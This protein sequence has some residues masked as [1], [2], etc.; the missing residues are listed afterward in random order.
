LSD[1]EFLQKLGFEGFLTVAELRSS[2][3]KDAP[4]YP[5]VYVFLR[6]S[7]DAPV[8]LDRSVGGH[9]KGK[10][11]TVQISELRKA[12]VPESSI[13]YIGKA[14]KLGGPPT[15]RTRLRQYLDFGAGKPV[16]HWG[17]RFIWQLEDANDVVVC[18]R[19][20]GDE[21]PSGV[22]HNLLAEFERKHGRLPF[23]NLV[24]GTQRCVL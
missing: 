13:V 12:W 4:G 18:W 15:L 17:G 23:A 19:A 11:P 10:D 6:E 16:G 22:E 21:A 9:F 1:R 5:G 3:L 20:T 8:F 24:R 7:R 2:A 14:G